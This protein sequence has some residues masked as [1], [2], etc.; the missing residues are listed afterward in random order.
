MFHLTDIGLCKTKRCENGG[1]CLGNYDGTSYKC[2]CL[3]GYDGAHCNISKYIS[4]DLPQRTL[5]IGNCDADVAPLSYNQKHVILF[6]RFTCTNAVFP[7]ARL[8]SFLLVYT[9]PVC[10]VQHCNLVD[11]V[12]RNMDLFTFPYMNLQISMNARAGLV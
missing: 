7:P 1:T 4:P 9:R 11:L 10:H 12:D 8:F 3:A 2:L 5:S 6:L